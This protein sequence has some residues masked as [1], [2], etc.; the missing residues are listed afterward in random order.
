MQQ[1]YVVNSLT[2]ISLIKV[3]DS[4]YNSHNPSIAVTA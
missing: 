3:K 1:K 4:K 2:E